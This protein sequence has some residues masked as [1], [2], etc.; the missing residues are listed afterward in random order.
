MWSWVKVTEV[1]GLEFIVKYIDFQKIEERSVELGNDPETNKDTLNPIVKFLLTVAI[2][3]IAA[4]GIL[5]AIDYIKS[6]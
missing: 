1:F 5:Y 6:V 3:A 2:W 4:Y